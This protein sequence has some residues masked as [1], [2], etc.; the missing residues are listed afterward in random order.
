M[1]KASRILRGRAHVKLSYAE[2]I[3]RRQ[4]STAALSNLQEKRFTLLGSESFTRQQ[5]TEK[6]VGAA[7]IDLGH[8]VY[9]KFRLCGV[10]RGVLIY[11]EEPHQAADQVIK[12]GAEVRRAVV[13]AIPPPTIEPKAIVFIFFERCGVEDA[14]NVVAHLDG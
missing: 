9:E 8:E 2:G 11:L 5:A 10:V 4:V 6:R 12:R 1:K 14:E 7:G 13:V 3:N